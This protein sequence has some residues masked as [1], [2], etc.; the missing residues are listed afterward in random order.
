MMECNSLDEAQELL[1]ELP[2]VK[3]HLIEFELIPLGYFEPL[4]TL[5]D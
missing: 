3:E 2:L 1:D 5:F 4:E